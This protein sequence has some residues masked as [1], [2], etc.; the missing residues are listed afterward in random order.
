MWWEGEVG[1]DGG[2]AKVQGMVYQGTTLRWNFFQEINVWCVT[3]PE[4]IRYPYLE[5]AHKIVE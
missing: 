2:R 3:G 4:A 5:G 1:D